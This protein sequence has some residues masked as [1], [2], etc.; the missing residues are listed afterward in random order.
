MNKAM[1]ELR[2]LSMDEDTKENEDEWFIINV[3]NAFPRPPNGN[4]YDYMLIERLLSEKTR[5]KLV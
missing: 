3:M 2:I 1:R 4:E 5:H